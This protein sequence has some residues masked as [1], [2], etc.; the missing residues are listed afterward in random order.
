LEG[1]SDGAFYKNPLKNEI[2][3]FARFWSAKCLNKCNLRDFEEFLG[4][5]VRCLEPSPGGGGSRKLS[6]LV[7][8]LRAGQK[9]LLRMIDGMVDFKIRI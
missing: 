2:A 4:D 5:G 6:G 3:Q 1:H 8:L 7:G 9:G